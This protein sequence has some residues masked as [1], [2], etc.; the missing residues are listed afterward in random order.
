MKTHA[1]RLYGEMDL[2]LETFE[3]PE[4]TDDEI[5]VRVVADSL[6]MSTYKAAVLG[7]EHKR[8]PD[9]VAENPI[10]VGHEM[11][12]EIVRVGARWADSYTEGESFSLQPAIN[13][14]GSM[15]SPGYSYRYCGGDATYMIIPPEVMI[16]DCLLSYTG[17][18]FFKAA[19]AEPYSCVIGACRSLY[20]TDRIKHNHYLGIKEGGRM[21]IIGG[22]GPWG[23]Q[24]SIMRSQVS[25]DHDSS[26]SPTSITND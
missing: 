10:M 3:L 20:R 23:W 13:Y 25:S 17:E 22:C 5:L 19:L 24:R 21:A 12:G 9:D 11:A 15:D 7:A 16:M 8:V 4:I 6:C 14:K 26:S 18:G 2:R 1:V